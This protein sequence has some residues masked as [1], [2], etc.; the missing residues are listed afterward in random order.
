MSNSKLCVNINFQTAPT[1]QPP[2]YHHPQQYQASSGVIFANRKEQLGTL[3]TPNSNGQTCTCGSKQTY[4]DTS[5]QH[6]HKYKLAPGS[7]SRNNTSSDLRAQLDSD[8]SSE[9]GEVRFRPNS[10]RSNSATSTRCRSVAKTP[11]KITVPANPNQ[12][13]YPMQALTM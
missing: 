2:T 10:R 4:S 8:N 9:S 12:R 5:S 1:Q 6:A 13:P 7:F 11:T 3:V